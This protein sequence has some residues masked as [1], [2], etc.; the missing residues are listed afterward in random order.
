MV[1]EG[2]TVAST[3]NTSIL[4]RMLSSRSARNS[5]ATACSQDVARVLE[6]G[7]VGGW[8]V[9]SG[10]RHPVEPQVDGELSAMVH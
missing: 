6:V 2:M 10:D 1:N 8:A 3:P 9:E 5:R 7:L 4:L